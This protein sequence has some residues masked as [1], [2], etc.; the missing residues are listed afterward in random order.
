M[1]E[2]AHPNNT[3]NIIIERGKRAYQKIKVDAATM[4]EYWRAVGEALL[5]GRKMHKADRDFS[6]WCKSEGVDMNREVRADAMWY[7]EN[8]GVVGS[9][10]DAAHPSWLRRKYNETRKSGP[11]P[12]DLSEITPEPIVELDQRSAEKITKLVKRSQASDEG[13]ELAKRHVKILAEK[14][15]TT[16]EKLSKAAARKV[17]EL[18]Y[19]LTDYQIH[20]VKDLE[21]GIENAFKEMLVAGLTPEAVKDVFY[22]IVDSM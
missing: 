9:D 14:H 20:H 8:F 2:L 6:Q 1:N 16:V 11:L 21:E 5:V 22:R 12:V 13:S 4:R 10:T 15:G 17:P 18:Y 7:A 19:G 3:P